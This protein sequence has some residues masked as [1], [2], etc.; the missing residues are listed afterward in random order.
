MFLSARSGYL[1]IPGSFQR[2][3]TVKGRT[4]HNPDASMSNLVIVSIFFILIAL[5]LLMVIIGQYR[6]M[7]I[8]G[9]K[10]EELKTAKLVFYNK[11]QYEINFKKSLQDIKTNGEQRL[12]DMEANQ[13]QL[14]KQLEDKNS[15]A[16]TCQE[17][18]KTKNE[19][20]ASIEEALKSTTATFNAESEAWKQ[21]II[22]LTANL[23]AR[24]PICK[25]V[26]NN[27]KS[28]EFC[29]TPPIQAQEKLS[30]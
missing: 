21:E 17:Q 25:Y 15:E 7:E 26:T 2:R 8:I 4:Y 3:S 29:A 19:E 22:S 10:N 5:G 28:V 30:R 24:S 23:S 1:N 20:L 6:E 11:L 12:K 13:L 16:A 27:E 14:T 9:R 18:M